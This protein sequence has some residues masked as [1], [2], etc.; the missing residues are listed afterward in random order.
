MAWT[1]DAHLNEEKI[2]EE[3]ELL[4]NDIFFED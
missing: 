1:P 2:N 4:N 3:R